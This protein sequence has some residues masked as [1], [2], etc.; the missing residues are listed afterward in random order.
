MKRAILLAFAVLAAATALVFDIHPRALE[1]AAIRDF[2]LAFGFAAPIAY[3]AIYALAVFVPYGTTVL[4][5]A[6]GLA[7]GTAAGAILTF[8]V[9]LFASLLPMT[10]ARRSA[11]GWF[12]AKIAGTRAEKLVDLANRNAF[13]VFFYLRLLPTIPYEVQ[14]YIAGISRIRYREFLAASFLGNG[15]FIF[16][17]AFLG[18]G[19]TDPGSPA[20]WTA[21]SLFAVAIAVPPLVAYLV[22]RR[23]RRGAL[24]GVFDA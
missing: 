24:S 8:V 17:L 6:A 21:A 9:T 13:W 18:D 11:R 16:V 23:G 2:I 3:A 20:F 22:R 12:E 14:N 5:V 15:P 19:L 1:P 4:S 10:V 7:F